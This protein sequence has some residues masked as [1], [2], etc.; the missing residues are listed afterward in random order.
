MWRGR[1]S[2]Q[3]PLTQ[4]QSRTHNTLALHKMENGKSRQI[5][6]K[7][8]V[9][10]TTPDPAMTH[11]ARVRPSPPATTTEA[12]SNAPPNGTHA[13]RTPAGPDRTTSSLPG[14]TTTAYVCPLRTA[15]V[16][17]MTTRSRPEDPCDIGV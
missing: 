13:Y 7:A 9:S 17:S 2:I 11:P 8:A 4:G 14:F 1:L 3:P 12:S 5:V 10:N 16:F 15:T 6:T